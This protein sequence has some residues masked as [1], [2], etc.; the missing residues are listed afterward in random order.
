M[1]VRGGI[2]RKIAFP[3]RSMLLA[4]ASLA[5]A[6][7]VLPGEPPHRID[8]MAR[9]LMRTQRIPGMQLCVL[10][11]GKLV[12]SGAY[13]IAD[14]ENDVPVTKETE[15]PIAS[16]TKQITA[17]AVLRLSESGKLGLEDDISRFVPD[18]P[19]KNAG[20]TIRRLLNHTAGIRN[21][22]DLGDRY[23]KQ[24]AIPAKPQDLIDLFRSEPLDFPPGTDYH[25]SNSGYVLL[26]AVIENAS[27]ESYGDYIRKQLFEPLGLTHILYGGAS[28]LLHG[29]AHGYWVVDDKFVNAAH[30]DDSQGFSMGGVYS[31]A[32]DLAKWTEALH[33]GR[34]LRPE[35]YKHMITPEVLPNGEKLTY[36]EGMEL[37]EIGTYHLYSHAG[38]G[39]G[40][41]AQVH[42]VPEDDLVIAVL[43]NAA[44]GG[45]AIEMADRILRKLLDVPG[46]ADLPL[47]ENEATLYVGHYRMDGDVVEIGREGDHLVVRYGKD[48]AHRLRYQGKGVFAQDGRLSRLHF[49]VHDHRVEGFIVARYGSRLGKAAREN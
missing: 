16:I 23:W 5:L 42:D 38:G 30:Y 27:G 43:T 36:G 29:R 47:P 21:L 4:L 49:L 9:D 41:I 40:F 15:F 46:P 14:L 45:G 37:G 28:R 22:Q 24:S 32:A 48:D 8:A 18:F 26:G 7:R 12:A 13:G 33:H 17:A 39:V 25:Y 2:Q 44:F 11:H 10:R 1:T 31:T 35:S 34:V 3:W 6:T 20:V 19:V